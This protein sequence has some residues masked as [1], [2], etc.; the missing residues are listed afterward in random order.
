VA[1]TLLFCAELC[2]D[3]TA[4]DE[5][6]GVEALCERLVSSGRWSASLA[7]GLADDLWACGPGPDALHLAAA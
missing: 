3:A 2:S 7:A 5:F 6:A 1:D 4:R